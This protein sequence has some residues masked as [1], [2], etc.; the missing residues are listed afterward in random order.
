MSIALLAVAVTAVGVTQALNLV[1]RNVRLGAF[2]AGVFLVVLA[3]AIAPRSWV[4]ALGLSAALALAVY[5]KHTIEVDEDVLDRQRDGRSLPVRDSHG[6]RSVLSPVY[7]VLYRRWMFR[8]PISRANLEEK[9]L[10]WKEVRRWLGKVA[11]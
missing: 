10:A 9:S 7:T 8:D 6:L 3:V 2:L 4:T 5:G 1:P 11:R